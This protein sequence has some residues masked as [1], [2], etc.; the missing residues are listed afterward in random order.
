MNRIGNRVQQPNDNVIKKNLLLN[1]I[2]DQFVSN[3]IDSVQQ[4]NDLQL[5][6]QKT[7]IS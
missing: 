6:R 7:K 1:L 5:R 4:P 3:Q 2:E